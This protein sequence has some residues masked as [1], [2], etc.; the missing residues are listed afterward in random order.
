MRTIDAWRPQEI[1]WKWSLYHQKPFRSDTWCL[2][3]SSCWK[4]SESLKFV[5]SRVFSHKCKKK[6]NGRER[7]R[8][9]SV[10]RCLSGWRGQSGCKML[11][12]THLFPCSRRTV[13][14]KLLYTRVTGFTSVFVECLQN[15]KWERIHLSVVSSWLRIKRHMIKTSMNQEF[16]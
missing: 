3:Y 8:V 10:C 13:G 15:M 4:I 11:T 16:T 14:V 1:K 6:R 12:C 9:R 7:K 2:L 5:R